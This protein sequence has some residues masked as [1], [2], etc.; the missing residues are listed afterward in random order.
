MSAAPAVAAPPTP[1]QALSLKPIQ[2][3]VDYAEPTAAEASRCTVRPEKNATSTAWVVRNAAGETLRRFADTNRDNVVDIWSYYRDGVEVYRDVDSDFDNKADEYRWFQSAGSRWAADSD[4]DGVVDSWRAISPHEV[5]EEVV[6]AIQ[7]KD[8]DR[9]RSLL[10]SRAELQRLGAGRTLREQIEKSLADAPAAFEQLVSEQSAISASGVFADFGAARP[11]R[12]PAGLDSSSQDILTYQSVAALVDEGGRT[13]QVQIGLLVQVGDAWRLVEAPRIGDD[14]VGLTVSTSVAVSRQADENPSERMQSLMAK[15]ERLDQQPPA[16]TAAERAEAVG[17]RVALLRD[18]AAA[19][20][21]GGLRDQWIDQLADMLSAAVVDGSYPEAG[22][23]LT[24]LNK[25]AST[26]G[27]STDSQAHVRFQAIYTDWVV[28]NQDPKV[29]F[30]RLQGDWRQELQAFAKQFPRSPDAA[31]ALLQLGMLE[32]LAGRDAEAMK[33]YGKL[34]ADFDGT[35]RAAKAAGAMT[36]LESPGRAIALRGASLGGK[37]ASLADYRGKHVVVQ[38]WATWCE[39]CKQDMTVLK[40]LV[41]KYGGKGFAVLGV[42]L[43]NEAGPAK[44]FAA[45]ARLPWRHLHE[46][47]GLE[48]RLANE[49]GVINLPLMLLVDDAGKVA[50]RNIRADEVEAELRRVLK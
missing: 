26:L 49:M 18:L 19:T 12:L 48:G 33:W 44:S 13:E 10:L 41:S 4:Q 3:R 21:R 1:E 50:N 14:A 36:R 34:A 9:F 47:G 5:A 7:T 25:Q 31:E 32:D 17:R 37:S 45:K 20:P 11:S 39:P 2:R 42:N 22:D 24:A 43:D 28:K 46:P 30:V 40:E 35:P 38:Y 8:L 23:Q 27:A 29:D 15:L 6:S 16:A